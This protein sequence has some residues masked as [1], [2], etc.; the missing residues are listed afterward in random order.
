MQ[1]SIYELVVERDEGACVDCHK[2]GGVL[3]HVVPKSML[4][5]RRK[6]E[7]DQ[8]KNLVVLCI[9]C[10]RWAHTKA[11]RKRHLTLLRDKWD[12]PYD[13]QPWAG[14]LGEAWRDDERGTRAER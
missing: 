11:A 6:P 14:L 3:H 12:Y 1:Q 13:E 9:L 7:R 4:M 10:D 2:P 5:G 8:P